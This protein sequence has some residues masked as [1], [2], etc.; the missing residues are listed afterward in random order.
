MADLGG[1]VAPAKAP[2]APEPTSP[3]PE[4]PPEHDANPAAAM[5]D[6]SA[7]APDA[8]TN[9]YAGPQFKPMSKKRRALKSIFT[10]YG[11]LLVVMPLAF[12]TIVAILFRAPV[13]ILLLSAVVF[14]PAA[15][16]F[17]F[18]RHFARGEALPTSF[19]MDQIFIGAVPGVAVSAA[20]ITLFLACLSRLVFDKSVF[21]LVGVLFRQLAM[22]SAVGPKDKLLYYRRYRN[23]EGF[24]IVTLGPLVIAC[25]NA[26]VK[27][28]A[29]LAVAFRCEQ[30]LHYGPALGPRGALAT[31]A[32][33][34][35]G[36][37][38][39]EI[40]MFS[41]VFVAEGVSVG[42]VCLILLASIWLMPLHVGTAFY[43]G[44]AIAKKKTLHVRASVFGAYLVSVIFNFLITCINLYMI[45]I[46]FFRR[47]FSEGFSWWIYAGGLLAKAVIVGFLGMVC[48]KTYNNMDL[49]RYSL[50]SFEVGEEETAEV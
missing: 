18:I 17:L 46:I 39:M 33:A 1:P 23:T 44:V 43:M 16:I 14:L 2:P 24:K 48:K 25:V 22:L 31:A 42:S 11:I 45:G 50:P 13:R 10:F 8:P 40:A 38:T 30:L 47:Y 5:P 6:P 32:G 15:G 3:S 12:M 4:I 41:V 28:F 37:G 49:T 26:V 34:G 27:E 20:F 29:K 19:L 35:L 36:F 7:S 9:D 21:Q